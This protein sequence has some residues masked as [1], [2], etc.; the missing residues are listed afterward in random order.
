MATQTSW[1]MRGDVGEQPMQ[2]RPFHRRAG[3]PAIVITGAQAH[4]AFVQLAADEGFAGF[5]L[6]LQR[7]EF[8]FEPLLGR[9]AGVDRTAN[10]STLTR[11]AAR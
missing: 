3:E 8:L 4:P 11:A 7:I 2:S 10:P 9:F 6:C 5:A 1:R